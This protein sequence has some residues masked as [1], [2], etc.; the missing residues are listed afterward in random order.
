MRK[1]LFVGLIAAVLAAGPAHAAPATPHIKILSGR[2]DLVSG[3][4][5]LV[6]ITGVRTTKD[7]PIGGPVFAG[8]QLQP[9]TCQ[10]TAT[11]KQCNQPATFTFLYKSTASGPLQAYDPDHP[12]ADV[13]T[14][15]T[16]RGVAVPFVVRLETGFIDRDQDQ[17]AALFDPAKPWTATRPQ[18]QFNH[19]LLITHGAACG[20]DYKSGSAPGVTGNAAET[21]LGLGWA[22]MSNA[23][24]NSGHNCNVALQAESLAM[25]EGR[26]PEHGHC[27]L[28]TRAPAD[29]GA[30]H[31]AYRAFA[32]RARLDREHGDHDN[33]LIWEGPVLL[34]ADAQCE[35]NSLLAMDRW[36]GAVEKDTAAGTVATKI[37]RDKPT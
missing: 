7:H 29:P 35:V 13:A 32:V 23:L 25:T 11:D 37:A 36:L 12:P 14:T 19:K 1:V 6:R 30:F 17:I 18:P 34:T 26:R 22:T 31:D 8:P 5:A 2:P 3:G 10:A 16:D 20:V 33:Q 15:T 28:R 27:R 21:A 24:D 9:W 4:D